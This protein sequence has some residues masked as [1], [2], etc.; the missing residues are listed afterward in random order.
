[1]TRPLI[2]ATKHSKYQL[3][4]LRQQFSQSDVILD[5]DDGS[6]NFDLLSLI[7][8]LTIRDFFSTLLTTYLSSSLTIPVKFY[9]SRSCQLTRWFWNR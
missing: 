8:Q 2:S 6:S 1:M 3:L 7:W 4:A 9:D 5:N